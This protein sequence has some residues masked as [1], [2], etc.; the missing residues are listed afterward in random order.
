MKSIEI[1]DI[2]VFK[3][4]KVL[5]KKVSE[6]FQ[7][8]K[9]KKIVH[10]FC[11]E[12]NISFDELTGITRPKRDISEQ[13]QIAI[14]LARGETKISWSSLGRMLNDT[15]AAIYYAYN[16]IDGFCENEKYN[17]AICRMKTKVL[18]SL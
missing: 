6:R 1:K 15:H 2:P 16:R 11:M 18:K 8:E 12:T 7:Y 5:V 10:L 14:Y 9:S 3:P 17:Q 4:T 13:K